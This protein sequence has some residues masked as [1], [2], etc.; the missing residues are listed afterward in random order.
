MISLSPTREHLL[1]VQGVR[2]PSIAEVAEP[3]LR[4]AGLRI[5]P[6]TNGPHRPPRFIGLT[7]QTVAG[8]K[9][10]PITVPP[11]THLGTPSWSPDGKRFAVTNT[12]ETGVELWAG[13]VGSDKLARLPVVLNAVYGEPVHWMPDSQIL[14]CHLVV[15]ERGQPPARPHVP[16]GPTIQESTGKAGPVWTFQDLLRDKHDERLF[17]YYATAQLALVDAKTGQSTPFGKPGLYREAAPAPDGK[18]VLI[19]RTHRPYSYLYPASAFPHDVEVW[20]HTGSQVTTLARLPLEDQVPIEGVPTGPRMHQWLPTEPATVIWVEALDEGNPKK[21]VPH[22]DRVLRWDAPFQ[23][24]PAELAKTEH[25]FTGLT[26]EEKGELAFLSEYD[27]DRRWRRTHLLSL[28]ETGRPPRMLWDRSIHDRYGDPGTPVTRT[29]P[30]GDR[31]IL[32]HGDSI[33]LIGQGATPNGDRPFLDRL[34]LTSL[35]SKRLFQCDT[36]SYETVVA[37]LA[38][39][40]SRFITHSETVTSPPNYFVRSS[41][42]AATTVQALTHF[43][44]PTPQLRGIKKQLVTYK[45]ADGVQLSFTLYLPPDYKPGTRLPTVMWAYPLE[46]TDAGTAGQVSGS[47]HRFTTLAGPTHLFFLLQG[48]AVLDGATMPVIGDPETVN[49][50]YIEQIVS[51]AR[52][53]IDKAVELGVT[54]RNRVGVGGHSYGAFM[55]ANLLA[56]SDLFR[57]GIA[58]SGAYNRT[59]TP[60]GFQSERRPLWQAKDM[61]FQVSPFLHADKIKKP[62]LLIHGEADNNSGT[63]PMQSDRMY[64]AVRGNGGVVRYVSLPAESHGYQARESIE[65]TLYEMIRWFDKYVKDVAEAAAPTNGGK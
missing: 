36:Q 65:H 19:V 18:H 9:Q 29:L 48:Y 7:L 33:Y 5:N 58:R 54:D 42:G 45:R 53:A 22:R 47:P 35:Q 40:A 28:K 61:Y 21:K 23:G 52:A 49:N 60:F 59:L 56:H 30:S 31:A 55:T 37:L 11:N 3:M 32:R 44:D 24:K 25:R 16:D 63:F 8:G 6:R 1:L 12:T 50:T 26:C 10:Q 46:F 34:D 4:L 57:A 20:D 39:D 17:D 43:T 38:D 64:Q 51:S 15:S 27:R 62:L 14:L 13:E 41:N 2:Y